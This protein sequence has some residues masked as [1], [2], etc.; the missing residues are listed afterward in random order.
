MKQRVFKLYLVYTVYNFL[1]QLH[2]IND[3]L[4]GVQAIQLSE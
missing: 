1:G 2:M 4:L 3:T